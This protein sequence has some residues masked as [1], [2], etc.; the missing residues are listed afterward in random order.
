[1]CTAMIAKNTIWG[2][3]GKEMPKQRCFPLELISVWVGK[4]KMTSD[5][6]KALRFWVHKQLAEQTIC[7][8]GLLTPTQFGEVAWKQIYGSL[9]DVPRMFQI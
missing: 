2:F 1:M 6:S 8:L 7:S 4:D 3:S 9:H 5:T